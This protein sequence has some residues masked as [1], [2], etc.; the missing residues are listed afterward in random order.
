MTDKESTMRI[1]PEKL[2]SEFL[3][4]LLK[5]GFGEE[6]AEKCAEIFTMNSHGWS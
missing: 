1:A 6:Q 2:K 3:R 5:A 4:V